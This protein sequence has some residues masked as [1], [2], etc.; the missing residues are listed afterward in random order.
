MSYVYKHKDLQQ[1]IIKQNKTV[2]ENDY[3]SHQVD[4]CQECKFSSTN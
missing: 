2:Y 1:N 4:L 3:K